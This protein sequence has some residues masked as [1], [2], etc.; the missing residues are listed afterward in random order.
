MN[1]N[2]PDLFFSDSSRD[3]AMETDFMAKFEYICSFG[4]AAFENG[5]QCRYSDS[6]IFI[7]NILATLC[8]NVMKNGIVPQRLRGQ[9]MDLFGFRIVIGNHRCT[10]CRNLVRFGSVTQEIKT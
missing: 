6:K 9:Q 7:G 4:R 5:L 3:V 8:A 1:V 2:D 10:S